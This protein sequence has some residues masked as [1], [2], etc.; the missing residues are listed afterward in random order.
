MLPGETSCPGGWRTAEWTKTGVDLLAHGA[1][2]V[3][4]VTVVQV[5]LNH[6]PILSGMNINIYWIMNFL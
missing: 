1:A 6:E 5:L 3:L 2:L 4:S